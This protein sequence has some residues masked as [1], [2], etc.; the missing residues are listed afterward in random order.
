MNNETLDFPVIEAPGEQ[1]QATLKATALAS[2]VPIEAHMRTLA[3][4]YGNVAYTVTTP[5]GMKEA[6]AARLVLREEGRYAVRRLVKRLEAIAEAKRV[7]TKRLIAS[8]G[9]LRGA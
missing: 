5:K 4:R 3:A 8:A 1:A 7:S 2:F 6:K 9:R